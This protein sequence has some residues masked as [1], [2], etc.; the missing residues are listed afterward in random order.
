MPTILIDCALGQE[1]CGMRSLVNQQLPVLTLKGLEQ[2][3]GAIRHY[4]I[5]IIHSHH[6]KIDLAISY[7]ISMKMIYAHQCMR[8]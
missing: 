5:E 8:H 7:G 3:P 2:L 4:K 6:A 1:N